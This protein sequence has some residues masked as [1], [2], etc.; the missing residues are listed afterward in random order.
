MSLEGCNRYATGLVQDLDTLRLTVRLRLAD[1][2][3]PHEPIPPTISGGPDDG[4]ICAQC[5]D[6]VLHGDLKTKVPSLARRALQASRVETIA[7][8]A[9]CFQLWNQEQRSLP[10]S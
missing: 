7:L 5:D 6:I 9:D 1:G 3:R 4:S 2:R 8:H 10:S